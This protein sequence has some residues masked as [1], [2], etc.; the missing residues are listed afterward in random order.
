M[1]EKFLRNEVS[2][3]I[4]SDSELRDYVVS[5]ISASTDLD[6]DFLKENLEL[7]NNRVNENINTKFSEVDALYQAD[8]IYINIEINLAKSLVTDKKN[9]RYICN[10]VLKQV[11]PETLDNFKNIYQININAYDVFNKGKFIYRSSI[12]E[13]TLHLKRSDFITLIDINMEYLRELSY[14]EIKEE[15]S[16]EY[17][18]YVFICSEKEVR[19]KLYSSDDIMSKLNKKLEELTADFSSLYYEYDQDEYHKQVAY[20]LGT[21][22]GIKKGKCEIAQK[23]LEEKLDI[24]LIAKVT[25]LSEKEIESLR[26]QA[27]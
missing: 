25:G 10:L 16:L 17:L 14:N 18:L 27:K 1:K 21:N 3:I 20:E 22:D 24:A 7:D 12:M 6:Y 9:F 4:F 5:V 23:M 13:E 15:N 8:N 19:D 2:T 11:P 26:N